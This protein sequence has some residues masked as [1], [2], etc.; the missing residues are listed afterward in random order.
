MVVAAVHNTLEDTPDYLVINMTA[1]EPIN[2][3]QISIQC[4]GKSNPISVASLLVREYSLDNFTWYQMHIMEESG[5]TGLNFNKNWV[6][7]DFVWNAKGDTG[8]NG[9]TGAQGYTGAH[10]YTGIEVLYNQSMLIRFQA[11]NNIGMETPPVTYNLLFKNP[12]VKLNLDSSNNHIDI[13]G[14]NLLEQAPGVF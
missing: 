4:R 2:E 9:Y 7:F 12:I 5:I 1:A 6:G 10:G 13:N 11:S 14:C 3:N 8:F